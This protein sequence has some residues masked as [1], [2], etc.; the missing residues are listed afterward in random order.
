MNTKKE[1]ADALLS[2]SEN[3]L[4]H[5][6]YEKE[7]LFYNAVKK[8]DSEYVNSHIKPF[9]S[10]GMGVLSD[11]KV[12]N[13]RYHF[14]I[15]VALITRFCMEGG[16]PTETAYTLSDLYIR[17]AD[18]TE[19]VDGIIALQLEMVQDFTN[20]MQEINKSNSTSKIISLAIDYINKNI[21]LPIRETE[22]ADYLEVNPS[23]LSSLFKKE[24]GTSF[25]VYIHKEKVKAAESL[26]KFSN[27]SFTDIAN[28]LSF[29][30]HSHF[31]SVFKKYSG[32]TPK[33][34]RDTHYRSNWK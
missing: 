25:S 28:Y 19:T 27:L 11:N 10:E 2:Q 4:F 7:L 9:S 23:Y 34:Y 24:T 12:K 8:G 1:L 3:N 6:E 14:I 13:Y 21:H 31:I 22:I 15:S 5:A 20:R 29:S 18:K 33:E 16:M 17:K 26:L 30:S 32:M